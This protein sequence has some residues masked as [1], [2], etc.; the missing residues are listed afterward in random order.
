MI[1]KL[2]DDAISDF[3]KNASQQIPVMKIAEFDTYAQKLF[4]SV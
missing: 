2:A 4:D 3:M 1:R